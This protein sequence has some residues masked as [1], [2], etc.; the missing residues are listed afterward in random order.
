VRYNGACL[1]YVVHGMLCFNSHF[2]CNLMSIQCL[3][4]QPGD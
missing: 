3:G 1:M 4:L 2:Y